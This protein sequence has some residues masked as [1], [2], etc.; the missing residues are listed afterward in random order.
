MGE[1]GRLDV[2]VELSGNHTGDRGW[3][4]GAIGYIRAELSRET[5]CPGGGQVGNIEQK[6]R[7][8]EVGR[9]PEVGDVGVREQLVDL[10]W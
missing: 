1:E 4:R 3:G 2:R 7:S 5:M 8:Q 6:P 10:T 9:C